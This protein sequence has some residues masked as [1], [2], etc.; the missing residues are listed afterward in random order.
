LVYIKVMAE[1]TTGFGYHI[2][3]KNDFSSTDWWAIWKDNSDFGRFVTA[4][5]LEFGGQWEDHLP[6]VEFTYNNSYQSTI[7]M[8]PYEAL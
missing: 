5:I 4:C 3:F 6:L 2:E 7:G 1:Y 8:E